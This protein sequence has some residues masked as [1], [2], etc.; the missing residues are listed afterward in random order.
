MLSRRLDQIHIHDPVNQNPGTQK[1]REPRRGNWRQFVAQ[2]IAAFESANAKLTAQ[3]KHH[4]VQQPFASRQAE[5]LITLKD[6]ALCGV[7]G[8]YD[9]DGLDAGAL[10]LFVQQGGAVRRPGC[11]PGMWKGYRAT[12][13]VFIVCED[14]VCKVLGTQG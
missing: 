7:G 14:V 8:K 3:A 12:V 10:G 4:F 1:G 5:G 6:K 13:C 11:R 9:E 2:A